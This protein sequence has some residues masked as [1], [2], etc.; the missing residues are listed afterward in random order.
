MA[1]EMTNTSQSTFDKFVENYQKG[2]M[3]ALVGAGL[4]MN[5]SKHFLS[6]KKL[7]REAVVFLYKDRI[8][9]HCENYCHVN[10]GKSREEAKESY[11]N[12]V[13]DTEDLL[14]IASDYIKKKGYRE[15][16][17]YYIER[18]I[19]FLKTDGDGTIEVCNAEGVLETISEKSL[20]IHKTLLQCKSFL[21]FYT[22]NYDNALEIAAKNL[23][24]EDPSISYSI[25]KSGKDLSGN[26][27]KN[28]VKIHGSLP[29][30]SDDY[31]M[32]DGDR[33]LRY[34]IA[35]EDYATYLQ[36]HE[37]FSYLMRI[38]ML[39][40]TFCLIGFSGTDP[41][42][43]EWVKWMSDILN[44][45]SGDK[46]FL[47]DIDGVE[48]EPSM[49]SFCKNHHIAVIN[50]WSKVVLERI[51]ENQFIDDDR[52]S[53]T[54]DE[55]DTKQ[56]ENVIQNVDSLIRKKE[57][58]ESLKK[59]K[60]EDDRYTELHALI[61]NY[62]RIILEE[63]FK[64]LKQKGE[65]SNHDLREET[66]CISPSLVESKTVLYDYRSSW[67]EAVQSLYKNKPLQ[68]VLNKTLSIKENVRF[69]KVIF[70][71]EHVI[72]HL[73]TKEP[74]TEEKAKLFALA[75]SDIGQIP[76]YY[77]NYHEDD[78][79][80]N[81]LTLWIQ[82]K[83]REETLR[84]TKE[85]IEVIDDA[86]KYE[87]IQRCLF[88][89]DFSN[90]KE[91]VVNWDAKGAWTQS[92]A[93][94]M[95]AYP[96]LQT[97]A[98]TLLKKTIEE[99]T[100]PTEK[101]FEVILANFISRQ[102]PRPY[103]TEEFW[104]YGIEGQGDLLNSMMSA[105]R[106]KEEKPKRRNWI[107]STY[108]FGDGH[109][110]YCKSLR[111]LQFIIDS[112][113]YLNL[114]GTYMFEIAS[115][116]RVFSN[117]YE[118]FPYPCFFYS[119]QY[120]DNVVLR[121][122]GEDFAYNEQLQDFNRDI[123]SKSLAAI[124]NPD[125]PPSFINGILNITAAMYVAVDED[126]W[127]NLFLETVFDEFCKNIKSK[128][129][130]LLYNVK[131]AVGSIKKSDSIKVILQK[132]LGL[133]HE[134][135]SV[136]SDI[137]VNNLMVDRLSASCL[138]DVDLHFDNYLNPD[139]LDLLDTFHK[140]NILPEE[141][142]NNL[143]QVILDANVDEIPKNRV[144]LYQLTNLT[145]DNLNALE[146]IK[147]RYLSMDIWHCGVLSGNELG[148]TEPQY[149]RLNLLN[150]K[151][152]WNDDQFELIKQNLIKNVTAYDRVHETLH[153]DSFMK[154][155]QVKYLSDMLRFIDGLDYVRKS[156]LATVR[157]DVERLLADRTHYEDNI[158]FMMSDQSADVNYAFGNIYE[159]VQARGVEYCKHDLDFLIDRA[160]MKQPIALTRNLR[161]I[162]FIMDIKGN[163]ILQAGY[164]KKLNKL[165]FVY[166]DSSSWQS[167]DLRFAF[168]YLHSIA[169]SLDEENM[170]SKEC[171]QF[172]INNSFVNKFVIE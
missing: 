98:I 2:K 3:S 53:K 58:Y 16:I 112:G 96:D 37:A 54:I 128:N 20:S 154:T 7:M 70:P 13:L 14:Q 29:E 141:I 41:N 138:N 121:R 147:Q 10:P 59:Q 79:E 117:L 31:Y 85:S 156:S 120:D 162:K 67:E 1:E 90:A 144:V 110:D 68:G 169:K 4:S 26:L 97:D 75:V 131:F 63:L 83:E 86:S 15:A 69:V 106:G 111:I 46:I 91:L 76:S 145:C 77:N 108:H 82:L 152:S 140:A 123:L 130:E 101:L 100:N 104:K 66:D 115:W 55:E 39:Q 36:K 150:N 35:K 19:P 122:I 127:F 155:T 25:V 148:W 99:E 27:S 21:N 170:L 114:P 102:W 28:I 42:Y 153:E 23:K 167:L 38:A 81:K 160:I 103:S 61:S 9:L 49:R 62:K 18:K 143:V 88:H 56:N 50:L 172:W 109:G 157:D 93:M 107:G 8:E 159:S 30:D 11:V 60:T 124:I 5:V 33:H 136:V 84:G 129:D 135:E 105:L 72:N 139:A 119:I 44:S 47:L 146:I 17:D 133:L 45:E 92:K 51:F 52:L 12:T 94:R 78:V 161:C 132:L 158:D 32:F 43:M 168:N 126:I 34:I 118:H 89:L 113:I 57:E 64:Y 73:M 40:G 71:Q 165:L 164:D 163:E 142:R 171:A 137:I 149:I 116:Y 65:S 74:L 22:T 134:N 166:M 151:V 24:T 95:A 80:L 87:E 48:F 6:W 125:A